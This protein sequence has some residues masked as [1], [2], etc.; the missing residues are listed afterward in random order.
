MFYFSSYGEG[1]V[2]EVDFNQPAVVSRNFSLFF[3][4][5]MWLVRSLIGW[6]CP[7]LWNFICKRL[8]LYI[9]FH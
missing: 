6:V 8:R 4:P 9:Q 2:A 3:E 1:G 7:C 5:F